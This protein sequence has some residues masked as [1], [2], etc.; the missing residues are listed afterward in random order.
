MCDECKTKVDLQ[1]F[2]FDVFY[3]ENGIK[4]LI[5]QLHNVFNSYNDENKELRVKCF[6]L[7]NNAKKMFV[8]CDDNMIHAFEFDETNQNY[9]YITK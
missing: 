3:N 1:A 6:L 5:F 2:C 9:K 4:F 7:L 8:G